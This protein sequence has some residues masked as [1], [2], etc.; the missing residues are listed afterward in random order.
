MRWLKPKR[1]RLPANARGSTDFT[2]YVLEWGEVELGPTGLSIGALPRFQ[3]GTIPLLDVLGLYNGWAKVNPL[4]L[5]GLDLALN[6]TAFYLPIKGFTAYLLSGGGLVSLQI[7]EPWSVHL[8]ANYSIARAEGTP[9]LRGLSPYLASVAGEDLA[10]YSLQALHDDLYIDASARFATVRFATDYRINRRDSIIAQAQAMVWASVD[11]DVDLPP[12]LNMN[13]ALDVESEGTLRLQ[14][15]YIV[16][17]AYQA[18]WRRLTVRAGL[19]LSSQNA[20]WL[21]QTIKV[22]YRF[23]GETRRDERLLRGDWRGNKDD[24]SKRKDRKEAEERG[25]WTPDQDNETPPG[26]GEGESDDGG[27]E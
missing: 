21:I 15:A 5:G 11:T 7:L 9:D 8:G 19:G 23:G 24:K 22:N 20:A 16:S 10:E 6:A 1:A 4:R 12:I 18:A 26:A 27:E 13:E 3:L 2:A 25:V 17:L 14:D